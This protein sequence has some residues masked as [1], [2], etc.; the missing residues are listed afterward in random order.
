MCTEDKSENS[1]LLSR[2]KTE[3][4]TISSWQQIDLMVFVLFQV[5]SFDCYMKQQH[6]LRVSAAFALF[7]FRAYACSK[8]YRINGSRKFRLNRARRDDHLYI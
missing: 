7:F 6:Q 1:I 8:T 5:L 4:I 2:N 3:T